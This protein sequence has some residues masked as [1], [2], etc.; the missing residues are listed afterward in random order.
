[1]SAV[2]GNALEDL[3]ILTNE[4][5]AMKPFRIISKNSGIVALEFRVSAC[6]SHAD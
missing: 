3:S 4:T 6:N 2:R 1:M 5:S